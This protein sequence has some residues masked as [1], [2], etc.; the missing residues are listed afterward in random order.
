MIPKMET[1]GVSLKEYWK[2]YN[3]LKHNDG[4]GWS[5][6]VVYEKVCGIKCGLAMRIMVQIVRI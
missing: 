6:C 5:N 2:D 1:S 3:I 4:M